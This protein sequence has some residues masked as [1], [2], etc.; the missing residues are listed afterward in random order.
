[1][2]PVT[3]DDIK[4]KFTEFIGQEV[5]KAM[6]VINKTLL[7]NYKK[8]GQTGRCHI[9][10]KYDNDLEILIKALNAI[11][12]DWEVTKDDGKLLFTLKEGLKIHLNEVMRDDKPVSSSDIEEEIEKV[13]NRSEILDLRE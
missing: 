6:T 10:Y 2:K 11:Y 13:Q 9:S 8:V 3:S 5:Q 7:A 4:E 12:E 1:M